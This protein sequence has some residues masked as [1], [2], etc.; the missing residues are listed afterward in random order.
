MVVPNSWQVCPNCLKEENVGFGA[1]CTTFKTQLAPNSEQLLKMCGLFG[2][3]EFVES[4]LEL[5]FICHDC[6][7]AHQSFSHRCKSVQMSIWTMDEVKA[8]V[9]QLSLSPDQCQTD[10]V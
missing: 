7:S 2:A 10:S 8:W 5:R 4:L 1:V 9:E 6:K 3:F